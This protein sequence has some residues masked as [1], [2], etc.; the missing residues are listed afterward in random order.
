MDRNGTD[1]RG[2]EE[3]VKEKQDKISPEADKVER[4]IAKKEMKN[5]DDIP[6][7]DYITKPIEHRTAAQRY[8]DNV[9]AIKL[10]KKIESENRKATPS[11][12]E[13]LARY[14]GWG[15]LTTEFTKNEK[16]LD[17][18]L[19]KQEKA[20][21]KAGVVDAFYTPPEVVKFMWDVARYMGFTNGRI[22]DPSMGTGNFEGSMPLDMRS[23]SSITG[24]ELDDITS[25]IARQL[26]QT[27][28]VVHSGFENFNPADNY[29]DLAISNVP[30]GEVR[31][32]DPRYRTEHYRIHNYFIAKMGDKVRPGGLVM[33]VTSSNTMDGEKDSAVLRHNM[34]KGF[35]LEG[36]VRLPVEAFGETGTNVSTDVLVFRKRGVGPSPVAE[37]NINKIFED[38]PDLSIGYQ[39]YAQDR[40]GKW[41]YIRTLKDPRDEWSKKRHPEEAANYP[42]LNLEK[43]LSKRVYYFPENIYQPKKAPAANTHK[44]AA[45][46]V[47]DD[48]ASIG[49]IVKNKDGLLG[50]VE[51][52]K[53]AAKVISPFP[54][55]AQK[56][57]REFV[58][59]KNALD[60]VLVAQTDP[61][62]SDEELDK[63]RQTLKDAYNKFVRVNGYLNDKNNLKHI[64]RVSSA[65]RV[66]ALENY[67]IDAK[68]KK[69][70]V[71]LADIFEKRT[72]NA[73]TAPVISTASDALNASL[74]DHGNVDLPYMAQLLGASEEE[75]AKELKGSIIKDPATE[76]YV[77]TDEYLSGNVRQKLALA[78]AAASTDKSYQDNVEKLK[79]IIPKDLTDKD[80]DASLGSTYIPADDVQAFAREI[81]GINGIDVIYNPAADIWSV[82]VPKTMRNAE[83][84][85]TQYET[86][87]IGFGKIL[88]SALNGKPISVSAGKDPT[89]GQ[90]KTANDETQAANAI[91]EKLEN[92]FQ[93]WLWKDP[94]RKERILN[95]YNNTF[96]AE[97][98][99]KWNGDFLTL[100]GYSATAPQLL[101]HQKAA[102]WRIIQQR[103]T[104]IAHCVGAG[105]TWTMQTAG[106][107][108]RRMGLAR[109][110]LYTVPKNTVYQFE[111]EFLTIYPNA[112]ILVV[113]SD[114]LPEGVES[115]TEKIT[116]KKN[117]E[118]GE[119]EEERTKLTPEQ[120]RKAKENVAKRNAMLQKI[121][122]NDW[123]AIIM[124]HETLKRLPMSKEAYDDFYTKQLADYDKAI[125]EE[126]LTNGASSP[127]KKK[128]EEQ[129]KKLD[130]KWKNAMNVHKKYET[131]EDTFETLG[132]DQLFVDEADLFKN[133]DFP[134]KLGTIKGISNSGSQ[135]SADLYIKTQ[136]LLNNP[137]TH[138]VVFATGTPISNTVAEL[139]TMERYLGAKDLAAKGINSFDQFAK[140]FVKISPG[141]EPKPEGGGYRVTNK[142]SGLINA[143]EVIKLF[144]N[145]A[146]VKTI[147]DLPDVQKK[148]PKVERI[149]VEV[150]ETKALAEYR[151]KVIIPRA[152]RIRARLV[153]PSQ[154]N[155]L[156]LTS[157][158]RKA[159][160]DMRLISPEERAMLSTPIT[161]ENAS[162][163]IKAVVKNVLKEYK[164]SEK[165][166][167]AQLIFSDLG[168][169]KPPKK[170]SEDSE[171]EENST[172]TVEDFT[173]YQK[174]KDELVKAG[175]PADQIRFVHEA[176]N[177]KQKQELF[178]AVNRG[179]VR[180]LIGS[181]TKMGA[182]TNMQKKLVALHRL[183]IPWRP[184]DVD[185]QDGRI[186]RQGNENKTVRIYDYAMKG[187]YDTSAWNTILNKSRIINAAMSG[188]LDS[189]TI[190]D[191]SET[192]M[193]WA[194][195][196]ALSSNDPRQ[197]RLLTLQQKI[198][199]LSALQR[200]WQVQKESSAYDVEKLPL[201][202]EG[203]KA[204]AEKMKPDV[205]YAEKQTKAGMKAVVN[206][207]TYTKNTNELRNAFKKAHD[208][209]VAQIINSQDSPV[210]AHTPVKFAKVNGFDV[211]I[212]P[213]AENLLRI[214]GPSGIVYEGVNNISA[215]SVYNDIRQLDSYRKG[216]EEEIKTTQVQLQTA[217][218]LSEEPFEYEKDLADAKEEADKISKEMEAEANK[219]PAVEGSS[220]EEPDIVSKFSLNNDQTLRSDEE[221]TEELSHILKGATNVHG[222]GD[223]MQFDLGNVH[224]TVNYADN[225][226][227]TEE[228][229]A[230]ASKAYGRPISD[231]EGPEG[232]VQSR[233]TPEGLETLTM[234]IS[235]NSDPGVIFHE[236]YHIAKQ[237][238]SAREKAAMKRAADKALIQGAKNIRAGKEP[239]ANGGIDPRVYKGEEAEAQIYRAW[240]LDR[241][242][243]SAK[244][245]GRILTRIKDFAN[246]LLSL[247]RENKGNVFRKIENG[248]V[249]NRKGR[250]AVGANAGPSLKSPLGS[251]KFLVTNKNLTGDTRVKVVDVTKNSKKINPLSGDVKTRIKKLLTGKKFKME[252]DGEFSEAKIRKD[253]DHFV[254]TSR[255][256]YRYDETR[257]K[258][259]ADNSSVQAI[260]ENGIYVDRHLDAQHGS[261]KQYIDCY[262]AVRNGDAIYPV[263]II[264][265]DSS[266]EPGVFTIKSAHLYDFYIPKEWKSGKKKN[267]TAKTSSVPEVNFN[268]DV[269]GTISVS[270]LL[271]NVNDREGNPYV[272]ENGGLNYVKRKYSKGEIKLSINKA[273]PTGE[274]TEKGDAFVVQLPHKRKVI[275]SITNGRVL[276]E[277]EAAQASKDY[278][279]KI[280]AGQEVQGSM[281]PRG[282][283]AF[284]TLDVNSEEGTVDHETLHYAIATVLTNEE[285]AALLKQYGDEE[286]MV[287]A[288][289][290]W[291]IERSKDKGSLTGKIFQKIS[292]FSRKIASILRQITEP[293]D[294]VFRKLESGEVFDRP[295]MNKAAKTTSTKMVIASDKSMTQFSLKQK[296]QPR[297]EAVKNRIAPKLETG[298]RVSIA[299]STVNK[300]ALP[301]QFLDYHVLGMVE[302]VSRYKD[303]LTQQ[304]FRWADTAKRTQAKLQGK[305][306]RSHNE[307]LDLIQ[308]EKDTRVYTAILLEEDARKKLFSDDVLRKE[309]GASDNVIEAHKKVR[310]LL[311]D[312]RSEV[313]KV[314][315]EEHVAA[316]NFR[317]KADAEKWAKVP[318]FHDVK[319]EQ[320]KKG[321]GWWWQ[322]QYTTPRVDS[323]SKT[324]DLAHFKMMQSDQNVHIIESI[325]NPDGTYTVSSVTKEK[326]MA[327]IPGYIPHLFH[328]FLIVKELKDGAK[329]V[330]GSGTSVQEA[331]EKAKAMADA[332]EDG[333]T[334]YTIAP[335]SLSFENEAQD[336][337]V[338]GDKEYG[339]LVNGI[340]KS[341][342]ISLTEAEASLNARTT[343][344]H[345]FLEALQTRNGARG[346]EQN[347]KWVIQH[348]IASSSRFCGLDPFKAK[349][350]NIF[351]RKFGSFDDSYTSKNPKADFLKGYINS[352]IGQPS[353]AE[354]LVNAILSY[355][356][357]FKYV[358][359]PSRLVTSYLM[360]GMSVLKLGLSPAA[361]FVNTTQFFNLMG[362][363]GPKWTKIGMAKAWHISDADRKLLSELGTDEEVGLEDVEASQ[364]TVLGAGRFA[365]AL[366]KAR[367]W[368]NKSMFMFT[369]A[370]RFL[371][372]ASVLA[373]YHKAISEGKTPGAAKAYAIDINRK[374]NFEYSVVDAPRIFRALQGTIIGDM[375][376]QFHKYG[377]K[378]LEA[379]IDI[380]FNK[381]IPK[382]QKA[383]FFGGYMLFAGLFN[384]LP[385]QDLLLSLFGAAADDD[386]PASTLKKSMM[387]WAGDDGM[388]QELVKM[389]MYGVLAPA[390]IDISQRVGL[391]G[392]LPEFEWLGV[393]GSTVSQMWQAY[394]NSDPVGFAKG[395]SPALGNV[396]GAAAGYNTDS[397]GR[398]T[399]EYDPY[400]RVVRLLGFRTTAEAVSADKASISYNYKTN[401]TN[402]RKRAKEAY[403]KN[404]TEENRKALKDLGYKDKNI[405]EFEKTSKM[406]REARVWDTLSKEDKKSL[407]KAFGFD[408][409]ID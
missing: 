28:R 63:K 212:Y 122:M 297:I 238:L 88:E 156:K 408:S 285:K 353:K 4:K 182:G 373:A 83:S 165:T 278:G 47:K 116:R 34:E 397:K 261:N 264:A 358:P 145:I 234:T 130:S 368:S 255:P 147:Q 92:D 349:A 265:K 391:K 357:A 214:V 139:Y 301:K 244:L 138:G 99:R 167:G 227:M 242:A 45:E 68:T 290:K 282:A 126:I 94:A 346:W 321:N 273:F 86:K 60:D 30:F 300:M 289:R 269:P 103:A 345:I 105:K 181:T 55:N 197:A 73:Q 192:E 61:K 159:S 284:M 256:W 66:L 352:V 310:D 67:E 150:P 298:P 221:L 174:V 216:T 272:N 286:K 292:D 296:L 210:A 10:L 356:P 131:G 334:H 37:F 13:I 218:K 213:N 44:A 195:L 64:S 119:Y 162:P 241:N 160:L 172:E 187:S 36:A 222:M 344:R 225:I 338:V 400:E 341:L 382:A 232:K 81:T 149:S 351:E 223:R 19:T 288:Y 158:F 330:V 315:S 177:D 191:V 378:E 313:E 15:G 163:K 104:L 406:D 287:E 354:I 249:Y 136:W 58:D 267:I 355:V 305:W 5:A 89:P 318:F 307:I 336:G 127:N 319:I 112:K 395:I 164:E 205:T 403:L 190:Q 386:D 49:S 27:A 74:I 388:K 393:T 377:F 347:M 42:E 279:Q 32:S 407:A 339:M 311:K 24:V 142:V 53:S 230:E 247:F 137:S 69:P 379:I 369:K 154:D 109:K 257:K 402:E 79:K 65:G 16:E 325:A 394:Q 175:I 161:D 404:P 320:V 207:K 62:V 275:I 277:E 50:V 75:I 14:S 186:I 283:D 233:T 396:V 327:D 304:Y 260:L 71:K 121:R 171:G 7:H 348:H 270:E 113:T 254:T 245:I 157:D 215:E 48:S 185:Q 107:E 203:L 231:N 123:D 152:E 228:E 328:D 118:T 332:D 25:R 183:T 22:L 211:Q 316:K 11:E 370:E 155:M 54:K 169:P 309:F 102:V 51:I 333:S 248:E 268:S 343:N 250:S 365:R 392:V 372:R 280:E 359:R 360:G 114:T 350:I 188:K 168:V 329:V 23:K 129:K 18:I 78:I 317:D 134:T 26:Y 335:K 229:K 209:A 135:R 239:T 374:A 294:E 262:A 200:N 140:N 299:E 85:M 326:P 398:K 132:I 96:N 367:Q 240:Q 219:V 220:E 148:L 363:V 178:E 31:P 235:R 259:L 21:A 409:Q 6:G 308:D 170:G 274:I 322:V 128:L 33:V 376:L 46:A 258:I 90:V 84:A 35:I 217:K 371:R 252:S 281:E 251:P 208:K 146:D 384:A 82:K 224:V 125:Q 1:E 110:V 246:R 295:A 389:A 266:V 342:E 236:A 41:R 199:K 303:A 9:A 17:S 243:Q 366:D 202:I 70:R 337:V 144:R 194:E 383:A 204:K 12:Q 291:K 302:S 385:F 101:S 206:G 176:K 237:F 226:L 314:Y 117:K 151:D 93:K 331:V 98:L 133:L 196:Q 276:T 87:K 401:K 189:R 38:N 362:Y 173:V 124:S 263:R 39:K 2:T 364:E 57:M 271:G 108:L 52:D 100:P 153:D 381:S 198:D 143:P 166:K 97:V 77:T 106:M 184:R 253:K 95:T 20:A 115:T 201:K 80:I 56:K 76:T 8:K 340:K 120:Q 361:A 324:I 387:E 375:A 306:T 293:S 40:Y 179:D 29:F 141:V 111:K 380:A 399:I 43:E 180:V 193:S 59:I 312:V 72:V 323:G 91:R 405:K 3:P 390:G